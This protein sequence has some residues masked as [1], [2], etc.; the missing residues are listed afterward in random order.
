M[1]TEGFNP[2]I[3]HALNSLTDGELIEVLKTRYNTRSLT[4][5]FCIEHLECIE[6]IHEVI[7]AH[8]MNGIM[9]DIGF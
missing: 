9:E 6:A 2:G 5:L 8:A 4:H 7:G 3:R 1:L